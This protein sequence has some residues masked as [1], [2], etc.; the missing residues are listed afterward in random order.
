MVLKEF[1]DFFSVIMY[2]PLSFYKW[3]LSTRSL[4][5]L[6]TQWSQCFPLT[7]SQRRAF[8][9]FLSHNLSKSQVLMLQC[10]FFLWFCSFMN[11]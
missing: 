4:L 5:V 2:F 1:Q 10:I 7:R 9:S 6:V 8:P 3:T 11:S